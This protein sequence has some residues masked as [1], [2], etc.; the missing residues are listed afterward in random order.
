MIGSG[1]R[2]IGVVV[3]VGL[4]SAACAHEPP[5]TPPPVPRAPDDPCLVIP[6]SMAPPAPRA[7]RDF[8]AA[9]DAFREGLETRDAGGDS[10]PA[11][12]RAV[13]LDPT[14]GLAHLEL[15]EAELRAVNPNLDDVGRHLARAVVL[16]PDNPRAHELFARHAEIRGE[17]EVAVRHYRCALDRR[18]GLDDARYRLAVQ[19]FELGRFGE[20]GAELRRVLARDPGTVSAR[21]LLAQVLEAEGRLREAAQTLET[22]ARHSRDNPVLLR[23][24]A[25]LFAKAGRPGDAERLDEEADARDPPREERDLRPLR[26]SR[27]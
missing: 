19:L 27:R 6:W 7:E 12:R 3:A 8:S 10:T 22:A 2:S 11:F 4:L 5:P 1:G 16:L 17:R 13:E 23:R 15:A 18:A 25:D 20:A 21:V 26:P 14:F 9:Q 24:A